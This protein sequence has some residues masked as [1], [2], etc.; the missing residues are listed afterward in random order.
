[1]AIRRQKLDRTANLTL[2]GGRVIDMPPGW[3]FTIHCQYHGK[4][5]FDFDPYRE[6]GRDELAEH[7]RDA[8]WS[9]RHEMIG[10]TLKSYE[11]AGLRYFWRFLDELHDANEP[12]TRLTRLSAN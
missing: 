5:D 7:M 11:E 6:H 8:V 12:I 10:N 2:D 3:A 1:M 4:I 9:L